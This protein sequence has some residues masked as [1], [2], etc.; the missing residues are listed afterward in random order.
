MVIA[1]SGCQ[2]S[3]V[4]D[5]SPREVGI[6]SRK[7][8]GVIQEFVGQ[9]LTLISSEEISA[10]AA[11]TAQSKDLIFFGEVLTCVPERGAKWAT[12]VRVKRRMLIV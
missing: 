7:I 10:A 2:D 12:S 4:I 5:V 1:A 3:V 11:V 8:Y 9:T 6:R